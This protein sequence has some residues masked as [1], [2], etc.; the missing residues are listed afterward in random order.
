MSTS[1]NPSKVNIAV[2]ANFPN[3][4]RDRARMFFQQVFK[5]FSE[6]IEWEYISYK[7]LLDENNFKRAL[8][9]D[10]LILS[11]SDYI[12]SDPIVQ[13]K[14]LV[15][16][17]LVR[18]FSGP[19]FGMCFG[20]HLLEFMFG[21][22]VTEQ[23]P[24]DFFNSQD[25][26]TFEQNKLSL[27][28]G[29]QHDQNINQEAGSDANEKPKLVELKFSS[30][31]KENFGTIVNEPSNNEF[32]PLFR[33]DFSIFNP[34]PQAKIFAKQHLS[35]PIYGVDFGMGENNQELAFRTA[36]DVLQKFLSHFFS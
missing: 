29:N 33:D 10:G 28:S 5:P 31:I 13:D 2:I 23:V 20:H 21:G 8:S 12:I 19:I 4:I 14:M 15:E 18:Q 6:K 3:E 30:K 24:V 32:V 36:V 1:T 9:M 7:A 17:Y 34:T 26:L 22:A 35:K 16:M 27:A 11:S 25:L